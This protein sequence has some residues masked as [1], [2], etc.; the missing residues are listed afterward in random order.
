MDPLLKKWN[1]TDKGGVR[2]RGSPDDRAATGAIIGALT[3]VPLPTFCNICAETVFAKRPLINCEYCKFEACSAC[4]QT[5]LLSVN[6]Q[7]CMNTKCAG[8]WSRNF[9]NKHFSVTYINKTLRDH[10]QNVLF[11]QE[12]A[13]MPQTQIVIEDRL[14]REQLSHQSKV[15]LYNLYNVT[16]TARGLNIVRIEAIRKI[17]DL[18]LQK[19]ENKRKTTDL[20]DL[21]PQDEMFGN[22]FKASGGRSGLFDELK[23][24]MNEIRTAK[25]TKKTQD[26]II[27][28][29]TREEREFYLQVYEGINRK[30]RKLNRKT[31]RRTFV[32]KCA[33]PECRGFVTSKWNCGLCQKKTCMDCHEIKSDDEH[34]CDPNTVETV[35]LLKTDTKSCPGCQAD[36]FKI[37]GCD[38]MWC[39][40]CQTAFSWRTGNIETKI[41]NPHYYDWRRKK[42]GL[43][44]EPGDVPCVTELTQHF[45]TSLPL[46]FDKH[47][48]IEGGFINHV[49]NTAITCIETREY[50]N[51]AQHNRV[52]ANLDIR[53]A[54]LNKTIDEKHFKSLLLR[55]QKAISLKTEIYNV[56]NLLVTTVTDILFRLRANS[57]LSE[58]NECDTTIID[59]TQEIIK[60]VNGCLNEIGMTYSC[61][62]ITQFSFEMKQTKSLLKNGGKPP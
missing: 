19:Q 30:L 50:N 33:D 2:G 6:V 23:H 20:Q 12:L 17:R 24:I 43:E 3:L 44:R 41:H 59:E 14:R 39:T 28:E 8:E 35:K 55:R 10:K 9:I 48:K 29:E 37:D 49:V 34:C 5:Y 21:G 47:S 27:A 45:I 31:T 53:I 61:A 18:S 60:Y 54:Y 57:Q 52:D 51:L 26:I 46:Y 40:Q 25:K 58:K 15:S 32:R 4:C 11:Q 36:I 62:S 42:G 56:I 13:L 22:Y 1:K 7:G 16:R 38:Q